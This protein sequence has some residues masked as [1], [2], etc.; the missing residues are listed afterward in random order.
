MT[1]ADTLEILGQSAR[2]EVCDKLARAEMLAAPFPHF[3]VH[4]LFPEAVYAELLAQRPPLDEGNT[5]ANLLPPFWRIF[6]R[7]VAA[8]IITPALNARFLPY[9]RDKLTALFN[10]DAVDAALEGIT[11]PLAPR[12]GRMHARRKGASDP[13]HNDGLAVIYTWLIYLPDEERPDVLGTALYAVENIPA[14]RRAYI[15][16]RNANILYAQDYGA[17]LKLAALTRF[18]PNTLLAFL[19]VVESQHSVLHEID[20]VRYLWA[21][22]TVIKQ[23]VLNKLSGDWAIERIGPKR[24]DH[25]GL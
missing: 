10:A 7:E 25:P 21:G 23:S 3:I 17:K 24:R 5:E 13:P 2:A 22:R 16:R 12:L 6:D 1:S 4:D 15:N 9:L 20:V 8:S 19:N 14:L 11:A 18:K